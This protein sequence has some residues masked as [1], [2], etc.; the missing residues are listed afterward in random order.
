MRLNVY[1]NKGVLERARTSVG[2]TLEGFLIL[3][4]DP[5]TDTDAATKRFVDDRFGQISIADLTQGVIPVS[6]LPAMKGDVISSV[7]SNVVNLAPIT[8][9]GVCVNPTVNEVGLVVGTNGFTGAAI[10]DL[11]W[12]TVQSGHPTTVQGY[13]IRDAISTSGGSVDVNITL[14]GAPVTAQHAATKGY[15]DSAS[16]SGLS[17]SV[18]V[19]DIILKHTTTTPAGYLQCNGALADKDTYSALYAALTSGYDSRIVL[20]AGKPWQYQN[21]FNSNP[22]LH[23]SSP[24]VRG[25]LASSAAASG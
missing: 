21:G 22:Y 7:G 14:S 20:G 16:S 24:I 23:F 13:G 1:S 4:T 10:P 11:T 15:V 9:A 12:A 8:S 5:V 18:A 19:G 2:G 25:N 3:V 6:S 17:G